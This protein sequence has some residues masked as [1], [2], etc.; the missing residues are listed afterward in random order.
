[1]SVE[2]VALFLCGL[3]VLPGCVATD[4]V[5]PEVR[6]VTNTVLVPT[7]VPCFDPA[8]IPL[9]PTPT[10]VDPVNA[11]TDQLA[12]AAAADAEAYQTYARAVDKMWAQCLLRSKK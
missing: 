7:P 4:P 1:V 5:R 11:T 9:L 3:V 6:T 8:D 10:P 12:A 2:R